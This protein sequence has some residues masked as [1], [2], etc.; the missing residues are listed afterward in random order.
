MSYLNINQY[1]WIPEWRSQSL[2]ILMYLHM[3]IEKQ[4]SVIFGL[5]NETES[6]ICRLL[7]S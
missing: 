3:M 1:E 2:Y 6:I 7:W 4:L 5:L